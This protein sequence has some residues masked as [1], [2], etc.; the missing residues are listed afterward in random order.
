ML[1]NYAAGNDC[2]YLD[3][4]GTMKDER[5]GLPAALASDGVHPT[6]EGYKMMEGIVEQAINEAIN[7]K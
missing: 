7:V 3:Y 4:H 1:K 5:N 6:V 2:I